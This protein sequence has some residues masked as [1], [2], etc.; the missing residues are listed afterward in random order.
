MKSMESYKIKY[1]IYGLMYKHT[2]TSSGMYFRV[3]VKELFSWQFNQLVI[4]QISIVSDTFI[5]LRAVILN[6]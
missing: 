2:H 3:E 4:L 6:V 1:H 5:N